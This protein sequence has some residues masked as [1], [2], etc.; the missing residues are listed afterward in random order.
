MLE[1]LGE[2]FESYTHVK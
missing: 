2:P 1:N